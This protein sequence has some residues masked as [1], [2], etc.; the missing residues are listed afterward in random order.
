MSW[1]EFSKS[2]LQFLGVV[3]PGSDLLSAAPA[4]LPENPSAEEIKAAS[5]EALQDFSERSP[6]NYQVVYQ[7][8]VRRANCPKQ[9]EV[10]DG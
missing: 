1:D 3:V 8:F 7:E 4:K 6:A 10:L 5:K 2:L 9:V